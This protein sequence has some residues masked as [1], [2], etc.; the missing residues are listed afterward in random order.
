MVTRA[1][2]GMAIALATAVAGATAQ[3]LKQF[4]FSSSDMASATCAFT[5]P[6]PA[7]FTV[8]AAGEYGGRPTDFQIDQS[9]HE[10]TRIDAVVNSSNKPVILML[11]AYEPTVW[12]IGWTR[13]T[14][15]IGV[16]VSG[17]HRQAVA[18]LPKG[19]PIINSTYDNRGPCGYFYINADQ[20][21]GLNPLA[22]RVFG[23]AVDKV[24]L[25]RKGKVVIGEPF[26]DQTALL[27]SA[28]VTPESFRDQKAGLA[29]PAALADAVRKGI[30]RVA[31]AADVRAWD[32]AMMKAASADTPP[33]AGANV[34]A[35]HEM[36]NGYVVLKEFALPA[37]LYGAHSATF[38]VPKGVPVPTGKLGHSR[39]LDY[40]TMQ[41]TGAVCR[42]D[43]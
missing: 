24:Y 36:Y 29:G 9:G 38:I 10:A 14:D 17:Y 11:G 5:A 30:L 19:T 3:N 23:R 26:A 2:F 33:V 28:D 4:E 18:G 12:N 21:E 34:R 7:D 35:T 42:A 43:R 41:C 13:G 15:I 32:A 20:L 37:G 40:N 6:L 16:L 1:R 39:V 25:S 31:T 27:T 8:L 22:R